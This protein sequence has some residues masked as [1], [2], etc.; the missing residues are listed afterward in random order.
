MHAWGEAKRT[1]K[2]KRKHIEQ[3][4]AD[5]KHT[6]EHIKRCQTLEQAQAQAKKHERQT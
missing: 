3:T 5:W 4:R 2:H 1:L 6:R